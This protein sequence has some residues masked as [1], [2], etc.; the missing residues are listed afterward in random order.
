VSPAAHVA[1]TL[2]RRIAEGHEGAG[3]EVAT[4]SSA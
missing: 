3:F 4:A 1:Q 2:E